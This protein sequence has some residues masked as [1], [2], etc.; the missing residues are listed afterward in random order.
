VDLSNNLGTEREGCEEQANAR[1]AVSHSTFGI[2][3]PETGVT[4]YSGDMGDTR[5]LDKEGACPGRSV[6]S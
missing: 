4:V 5:P 3:L 2:A 6:T 1:L